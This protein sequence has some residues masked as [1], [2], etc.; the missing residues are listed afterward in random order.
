MFILAGCTTKN[1]SNLFNDIAEIET[2]LP[3][4]TLFANITKEEYVFLLFHAPFEDSYAFTITAVK[5]TVDN[6]LGIMESATFGFAKS[7]D[8]SADKNQIPPREL[9][10]SK[11]MDDF[12]FTF[13][14]IDSNDKNV[15]LDNYENLIE[16][17]TLP[18][19]YY[20]CEFQ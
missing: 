8:K 7:A 1:E 10:V 2:S 12:T 17:T 18:G 3:D 6:K 15:S 4:K 11:E 19:F 9:T 16:I 13:S 5:N 14:F 20:S